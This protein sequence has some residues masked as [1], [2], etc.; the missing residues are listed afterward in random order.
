M[1][2]LFKLFDQYNKSL[3]ESID[4]PIISDKALEN[5]FLRE[6]LIQKNPDQYTFDL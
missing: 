5:A 3:T 2:N 4:I 6:I 1:L